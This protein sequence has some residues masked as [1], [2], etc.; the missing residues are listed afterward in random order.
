MTYLA[1]FI[2]VLVLCL[3]GS[4]T[5]QS[6]AAGTEEFNLTEIAAG[7]YVHNGKHVG[8]DSPGHDDIANIGFIVG[9]KCVA[10]I[11]TGGS[12][13]TGQALLAAIQ[14][15]TSLPICFVI[16]THI[17][18]D[19]LLGNIVFRN[20]QVKF[21]GHRNLADEV[22]SSRG[23]FLEQFRDDLGENPTEDSIIAPNLLVDATLQLDLGKRLLTLK[24]WKT[25]HS[26][27]DLS[28][29]DS[30]TNTLWLSDLLFM[31]RIPALD[32]S[33]KNWLKITDELQK[34]T[35]ECIVPG[36]G[37]VCAKAPMAFSD[38]NRYLDI[39]LTQTRR[40]IAEGLFMEDIVDTVGSK[41]KLKW[42][43]YEQHH[44]R[45]V[46]RAFSELEWE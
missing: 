4:A 35:A 38:Q 16:N 9:E 27:T 1:R 28:V 43:L 29:Y 36:H 42:L 37:P 23:F 12:V 40:K 24:A 2:P 41:E 22:I 3:C 15:T 31:Q 30:K 13:K 33:L 26:H 21:V 44:K 20:D 7:I 46:T 17:H 39:L 32:G 5:V 11:D 19:H 34:T 45:N 14:K 25:A 18:F 8:F 6:S 10:V